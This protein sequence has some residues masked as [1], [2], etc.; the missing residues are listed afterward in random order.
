MSGV[1]KSGEALVAG[2]RNVAYWP[3]CEVSE[4]GLNVG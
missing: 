3:K 1:G 2:P 4:R